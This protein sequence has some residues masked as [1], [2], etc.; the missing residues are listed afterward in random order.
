MG[1][2]KVDLIGLAIVTVVF[3]PQAK[4]Q[5]GQLPFAFGPSLDK[6]AERKDDGATELHMEEKFHFL[7]KEYKKLYVQK[8]KKQATVSLHV[9]DR[10][11]WCSLV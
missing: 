11:Q 10:Y 9:A 4:T 3:V 1:L 6:E 7:E 8:C 5:E 2:G